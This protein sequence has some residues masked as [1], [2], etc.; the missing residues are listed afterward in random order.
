MSVDIFCDLRN[1][2]GSAR[3]QDQRPTCLAFATSD[4]HAALRSPWAPLSVEFIYY[5]AQRRAGRTPDS[6]ATLPAMLEALR[7]DGQP[8]EAGWPY[9]A[10]VPSDWQPAESV[11]P[12]YRRRGEHGGDTVSEITN[13]LDE[14]KPVLVLMT[15]SSAFDFASITHGIVNEAPGEQT[16]PHRRHAVIAAGHGVLSQKRVILIRNSWGE[17]WGQQGYAWLTEAY[18]KPRVFR[19]SILTEDPDV[20][21]RSDAA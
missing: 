7:E 6:G 9:L 11:G 19:I 12:V 8:F 15:L 13:R 17:D 3:D 1:R 18:L 2:F 21:T 14:G 16:N 10:A 20:Y 5:H 4:A